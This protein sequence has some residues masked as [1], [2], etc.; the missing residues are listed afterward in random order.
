MEKVDGVRP[1]VILLADDDPGDQE[2]TRRAFLDWRIRNELIVVQDGEEALD[3]LYRRGKFKDPDSSPW[4]DLF[5]LDLNMPKIDGRQ[6]L[7][8][9]QNHPDRGRITI[10]VLTT[11]RQEQDILRSYDLGVNSFITKPVRFDEFSALFQTLG[12]YWFEIV[13]LPSKVMSR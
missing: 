4:P 13:V 1:A 11:S 12:Q 2:L 9:L 5:L 6:V 10:V 7:E 3:Y 8:E